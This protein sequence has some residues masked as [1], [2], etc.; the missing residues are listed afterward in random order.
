MTGY[1]LFYSLTNCIF[2]QL[3]LKNF[4]LSS[5]FLR[6]WLPPALLNAVLGSGTMFIYLLN[7]TIN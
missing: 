2:F 4:L 7:N 6:F 1:S 5:F 3:F